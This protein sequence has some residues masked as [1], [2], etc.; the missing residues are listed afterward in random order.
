MTAPTG[1][2]RD[3]LLA[4]SQR[5]GEPDWMRQRRLAA[6]E[7]F[8]ATP[9]PGTDDLEDWRRT[10]LRLVDLGALSHLATPNGAPAPLLDDEPLAGLAHLADG[11][12][13]ELRLDPALAARG[14]VLASLPEA[15]HTHR[16]LIAKHF[17]TD[18]VPAAEGKFTLLHAAFWNQGLLLYVPRG[19]AIEAPLL[20]RIGLGRHGGSLLHHTL[21]I[22]EEGAQVALTEEF[23]CAD[24]IAGLSV[25]V[26][27]VFAGAGANVSYA[28]VQAWGGGVYEVGVKRA[29][30]GP[31]ATVNLCAGHLGGKLSKEFVGALLSGRGARCDLL[32]LYFPGP[33]QHLDQT[34][35]QDHR[36]PE[37]TSNLLFKGAVG[38]HGRSVF[39]GVIN[40]EPEAQRTDAYQTNHNLLLG[41]EARADSMPVLEIEADDVK[42]SHG[43]TLAE[44]D[45]EDLFY[46]QSRGVSRREAEQMVISGFF[47]PV[48]DRVPVAG[49][50]ARLGA[51]L[52]ARIERAR[53]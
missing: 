36:Q 25:P 49:V 33:G 45:A 29:V 43:A 20:A 2:T 11:R 17:M 31:N 53:G 51:A 32:G 6:F 3:A 42:C 39:R 47:Q 13:V 34:T 30:C 1:F 8:E 7:A 19:V 10:D 50:R 38:D 14:V 28:T 23:A 24:G 46:L 41:D 40:V 18:C 4:L 37:G 16:E 21:V 9:W 48:I 52:A 5:L 44:L 22:V 27:E 35:L 15:L 12:A 26:T